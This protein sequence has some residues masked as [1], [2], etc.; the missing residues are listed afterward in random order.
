MGVAHSIYK[1]ITDAKAPDQQ[2]ADRVATHVIAL[3]ATKLADG[4][5]DPKLVLAWLLNAIGAPGYLIGV[6]VPVR[7]SG[8]L[9]PQLAL[10]QR[11]EQSRRRKYYWAAGS[12][13]QGLAALGMAAAALLLPGFW[14]GWVIL[15]CL[16]LLAVARSACSASYKDILARTVDKGKRGS[17][18]GTAGTLA[19]SGVFL[20]AV[21]LSTGALP[22]TTVAISL[23]VAL[24][25]VFWLGSAAIFARLDEPEATPQEAEDFA[26][27][28]LLRPLKKDQELRR[29]IGTR[30]LLISTALA[31]PF[32]VML[33]GRDAE[34]GFGNLGLLVLA[35]S[36]AAI[37]SSYIWGKLSDRSSRQTLMISGALSAV[38]LAMAAAVGWAAGAPASIAVAG[39]VFVAQV[40]YQG[41][42]AGRKTHLTDMDTHGHTSV[43]TALSNTMIGV[44]LL[45]G[46]GFGLLADA[47]G[48]APVLAILAMLSGLGAALGT[49]L[50]EVQADADD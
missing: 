11:I 9:L 44:L 4:L 37:V 13:L 15:I 10:A 39:F 47:V 24:A 18:S 27:N 5:I 32:L 43:Y 36:I 48:T 31:P 29:Y 12:A 26:P 7:E 41:A 16:A 8:S 17:V 19:A 3:T 23:V 1:L 21:L 42:R 49:R 30:A 33:G 45:L 6:L 25:G 46:G 20:F 2:A 35:S 50:S 28:Q 40:A 38:T 22:R 34:G 14:A